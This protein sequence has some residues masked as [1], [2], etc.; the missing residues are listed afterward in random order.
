MRWAIVLALVVMVRA[1]SISGTVVD[2]MGACIPGAK[3]IASL[4]DSVEVRTDWYGRFSLS[5]L[6]AGVY[7]VEISSPG[8]LKKTIESVRV[9]D[10]GEVDLGKI[11]LR[12]AALDFKCEPPRLPI[13]VFT[14]TSASRFSVKGRIIVRT[15]L[16][17]IRAA[18]IVIYKDGHR[19]SSA[20]S[21]ADGSFTLAGLP[22]GTYEIRVRLRAYAELIVKEVE[23]HQGYDSQAQDFAVSVCLNV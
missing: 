3:I 15:N 22:A 2:P 5:G 23:V 13:I 11:E 16:Q 6:G 10:D 18:S 14:P 20:Q 12:V 9:L 8:F 17:T 21:A 1:G 4:A 7:V 19:I